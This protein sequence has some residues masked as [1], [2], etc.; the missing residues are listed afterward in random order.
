MSGDIDE[1]AAVRPSGSRDARMQARFSGVIL[2]ESLARLPGGV[3][4]VQWSSRRLARLLGGRALGG[5]LLPYLLGMIERLDLKFGTRPGQPPVSFSPGAMTVFVGPNN[6]GKSVLLEDINLLFSYVAPI[7]GFPAIGGVQVRPP[8]TVLKDLAAM[9]LT[10][11][12]SKILFSNPW[13]T[14]DIFLGSLLEDNQH[15][16]GMSQQAISGWQEQRDPQTRYQAEATARR[17]LVLKLGTKDRLHLLR[18]RP[19]EAYG[20]HQEMF[21]RFF[22]GMMTEDFV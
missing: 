17:M 2:Q 3:K 12:D 13:N 1:V 4:A 20:R 11:E 14:D 21:F 7:P 18:Q 8:L 6:G 22:F 5:N 16:Q 15:A 19:A 10:P 9:A